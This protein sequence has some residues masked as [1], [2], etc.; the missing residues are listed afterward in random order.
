MYGRGTEDERQYTFENSLFVFGEYFG[1]VEALRRE[2]QFLDMGGDEQNRRI[3]ACIERVTSKFLRDDLEKEFRLFRGQQRAIGEV[4]LVPRSNEGSV[5]CV[6][7]AT[8]TKRLADSEFSRWFGR[9]QSDLEQLTQQ[10]KVSSRR[11]EHIQGALI[12]LMDCLDPEGVRI[13]SG[14]RQKLTTVS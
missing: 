4:M 13:P 10:P 9:L 7:M 11:I 6:G 12:D 5:E 2:V 14:R 3:Q 1:W 8:F